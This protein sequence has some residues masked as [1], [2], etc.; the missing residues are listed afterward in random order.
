MR[1]SGRSEVFVELG[2]PKGMFL[3]KMLSWSI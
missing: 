2:V 3:A 1:S